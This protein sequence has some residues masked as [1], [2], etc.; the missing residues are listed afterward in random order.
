MED[1]DSTQHQNEDNSMQHQNEEARADQ[2]ETIPQ[3]EK[4][5]AK[6]RS[7]DEK[8]DEAYE[9]MKNVKKRLEDRDEMTDEFD[10]YGK[11]VGSELR[12]IKDEYS[13]LIAKQFINNILTDARLGKYRQ[14]Y[15]TYGYSTRRQSTPGT[16][17]SNDNTTNQD[18]VQQNNDEDD[19]NFELRHIISNL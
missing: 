19:V 5:E 13:T 14:E 2:T 18:S 16:S 12:N 1:H 6:K 17:A 8:I 15:N 4:K 11:Y 3:T 10:V 7:H 9:V